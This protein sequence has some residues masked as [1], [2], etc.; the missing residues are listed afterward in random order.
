MRCVGGL[1]GRLIEPRSDRRL[2]LKMVTSHE[3]TVTPIPY[4]IQSSQ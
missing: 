2:I 4:V 1:F 3:K